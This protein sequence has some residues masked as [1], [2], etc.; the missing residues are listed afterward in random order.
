MKN[1][2]FICFF[3]FLLTTEISSAQMYTLYSSSGKVL[4]LFNGKK[5]FVSPNKTHLS[6]NYI[7]Y[8]NA[9]FKVQSLS[10]EKIYSCEAAPNGE[11]LGALI[12]NKYVPSP[13]ISG[14]RGSDKGVKLE[15]DSFVTQS[16][17]G[18]SIVNF[19][20]L[21]VGVYISVYHHA[22]RNNAGTVRIVSRVSGKNRICGL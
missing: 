21:L 12:K 9:A 13:S 10:T 2:K 8:S 16:L 20:Y 19:H 17:T 7:I 4:Y 11:R 5:E 14:K 15:I 3:L 6:E 22:V 18:N 1:I